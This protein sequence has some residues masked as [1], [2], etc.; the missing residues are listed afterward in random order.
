MTHSEALLLQSAHT[1]LGIDGARNYLFDDSGTVKQ[2]RMSNGKVSDPTASAAYVR[3][4]ATV[5]VSK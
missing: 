2:M 3:P 4:V 5:T 1:A